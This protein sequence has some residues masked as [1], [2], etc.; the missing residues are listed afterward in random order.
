MRKRTA[1]AVALYIVLVFSAAGLSAKDEKTTPNF[2]FG[3]YAGYN[4]NLHSGDFSKLPGIDNCCPQYTYGFGSGFALGLLG[5]YPLNSAVKLG[6]RIGYSSF[7]AEFIENEFIGN[8]EIRDIANPSTSRIVPAYADHYLTSRLSMFLFEPNVSFHFFRDFYT[9]AGFQF[10]FLTESKFDQKEKLTEPENVVFKESGNL[11][12]NEQKDL[13]IPEVNSFQLFGLVALGYNLPIGKDRYLSPEI[14]Y[15]IPFLNV[16]SVDWKAGSLYF[17]LAVKLPLYPKIDKPIQNKNEIRRDT[18]VINDPNISQENFV[19]LSS[20]KKIEKEETEEVIIEKTI[21]NEKWERRIPEID[22]P[23]IE[24]SARGVSREGVYQDQPEFV[25]EETETE[26]FFPLLPHIFFAENS[27]MLDGKNLHLITREQAKNFSENK[28]PW[29]T[30]QI[31]SDALNI[32]GSRMKA[33]PG[34]K[35]EITGCNTSVGPE[36]GNLPISQLRAEAVKQYLTDVWEIGGDRIKVKA[37]NLPDLPGNI[38]HADGQEENRRAELTTSDPDLLKPVYLKDIRKTSNPPL[39]ELKPEISMKKGF[40]S[41]NIYISQSGKQL[42]S[43]RET[44]MKDKILWDVE[45]EPIP[46]FETPVSIA[47]N[48]AGKDGKTNSAETSIKIK[49]LTIKKKRFEYKDDKKIERYSLI[50]FDYNRAEL[51]TRQQQILREIKS[52][53]EPGSTVTIAGYTDRTGDP[54]Y[55]KQLAMKR[56]AEAQKILQ[57]PAANLKTEPVGNDRLLFDNSTPQ[58]RSYCRTVQLLIET[59]IK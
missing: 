41:Y 51:N 48:V 13:D 39:V 19:L 27:A 3:G 56:V 25:I 26:E 30:M 57:L 15:N 5:E 21:I 20:D 49:Q 28:L 16:S 2:Y 29:N 52:R 53:I 58:G 45:Q 18:I 47:L 24:I 1:A 4:Y 12:R 7:G 37:Q 34:S 22:V 33:K 46:E 23:I 43:Y 42:R 17:G 14:R 36:K 32:I 8:T 9:T 6:I 11:W 44:E 55:N 50:L 38:E 40:D 35:L 54:E 31:Y 59:P 10:G